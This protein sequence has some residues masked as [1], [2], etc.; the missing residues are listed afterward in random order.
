MIQ[1]LQRAFAILELIDREGA[2]DD[3][4]SAQEVAN[5][6]GLKYPTTHNFLKSLVALGYL[7]R[8]LDTGKYRVSAKLGRLGKSGARV[9]ALETA[10]EKEIQRLARAFGETVSLSLEVDFMRHSLV[11]A[12][13][14]QELRVV[15]R[16]RNDQFF[17]Y[18]VGRVHLSRMSPD[19]LHTYVERNGLP[20]ADW[21]GI[22]ARD[23]LDA[24]LAK[25]RRDGCAAKRNPQVGAAAISVPI[26]GL[27]DELNAALCLVLPLT[28]FNATKCR[29]IVA[30]LQKAAENITSAMAL[31]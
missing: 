3:G 16:R 5:R 4:M 14:S 2:G 11:I 9:K 18:P 31:S 10:G 28:R 6:V 26:L 15:Q 1:S 25:I 19:R 17:P 22:D 27:A 29:E 13:S 30:A 23:R 8:V 24:A 7:E 20:G 21:D 12:E